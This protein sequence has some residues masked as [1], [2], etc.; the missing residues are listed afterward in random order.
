MANLVVRRLFPTHL[1]GQSTNEG[2]I[3]RQMAG[4]RNVRASVRSIWRCIRSLS[5]HGLPGISRN[6]LDRTRRTS[7][8]NFLP[9]LS[10]LPTQ[11]LLPQPTVHQTLDDSLHIVHRRRHLRLSIDHIMRHLVSIL[12]FFIAP[13]M[14]QLIAGLLTKLLNINTRHMMPTPRL[15]QQLGGITP[16]RPS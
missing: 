16:T 14:F 6:T 4:A 3:V 2:F 12:A 1:V 11:L 8:T 13:M 10:I 15:H 7:S 5:T 9:L